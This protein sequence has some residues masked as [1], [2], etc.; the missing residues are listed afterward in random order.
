MPPVLSLDLKSPGAHIYLLTWMTW[1]NDA[2]RRRG[3]LASHYLER[4]ASL[5]RS[6]T[7]GVIYTLSEQAWRQAAKEYGT[8][9]EVLQAMPGAEALVDDLA[10]NHIAEGRKLLETRLLEPAGGWPVVDRASWPREQEA[11]GRAVAPTRAVGQALGLIYQLKELE[12]KL[13]PASLNRALAIMQAEKKHHR[14]DLPTSRTIVQWWNERKGIAPL[15]TALNFMQQSR[16]H[17]SAPLAFLQTEQGLRDLFSYAKGLRQWATGFKAQHG[18]EPLIP[19]AEAVVYD[20]DA[21]E[22][23]PGLGPL[24]SLQMKAA[25]SY[26]ATS[27]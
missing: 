6:E 3:A 26:R 12:S 18:R 22:R 7:Q 5:E 11:I 14:T 4:K 21:P 13:R 16:Q 8:T 17:T 1:P 10:G 20:V 2:E 9:F 24:S 19:E 25:L 27:G 23:L 15:C